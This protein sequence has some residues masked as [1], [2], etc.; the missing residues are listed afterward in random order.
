MR[1]AASL[2]ENDQSVYLITCMEDQIVNPHHGHDL[3]EA[4]QAAGV[5][6]QF[7]ELG[8]TDHATGILFARDEYVARLGEFL[9]NH[10][11]MTPP[12]D[13]AEN[14]TTE[15]TSEAE[16]TAPEVTPEATADA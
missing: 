7:W 3:Y 10:F 15:A 14:A 16:S 2:A 9:G 8:C 11:G 13:A 6:V 1:A 4:F 5:D 12:L